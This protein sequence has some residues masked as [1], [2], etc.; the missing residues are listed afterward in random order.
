MFFR[1]YV[2]QFLR[3]VRAQK[4]RMFLTLFGLIWGTAAVTLL[5]AFGEGLGAQVKKQQ[6]GLGE[7]IVIAWPSR[8]SRPWQGLP[9]GRRVQVTREDV[10]AIRS[11]IPQITYLSGEYSADNAKVRFGSKTV[12]PSVVG[13]NPEFALMRNVIPTTG[14][15]FYNDDDMNLRRRV[16]FIG[17]ELARDLFGEKP[18]VGETLYIDAVPF[19]VIGVMQKKGQDSSYSGRD[20]DKVFVPYTTLQAMY[21]FK[22]VDNFVFQLAN[23]GESEAAKK[24]VLA[25]LGGKYRFDPEDEEAIGMWDTTEGMKFMDVFFGVFN[26]FL[27]VVGA[28]TLVVGGIGVSNIMNVAVEERTKEVG[29]KM[30]LG[31]K[32][33]YVLGQFLTETLLITLV[34]GIVGFAIS[35]SICAAFP[36][37]FEEYVGRPEISFKVALV[38]TAILGSIGLLA[39][40]FPART[41]ANLKPVEALRM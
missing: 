24:Q 2:R 29:I 35:W 8:T 34:G 1:N 10:E 18:P 4:L 19:Q 12:A 9:R 28:M 27:G 22:Y 14:G 30:A 17:D 3:D 40:W 16:A 15:R 20:K 36:A 32:K 11:Q 5:L 13:S 41:A 25:L 7:N 31:A 26:T 37:Q 6:K 23:A 39:G 21:G 38:T 33:R